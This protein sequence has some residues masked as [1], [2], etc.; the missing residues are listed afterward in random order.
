MGFNNPQPDLR[1]LLTTLK[2][3]GIFTP[4]EKDRHGYWKY[5]FDRKILLTLIYNSLLCEKIKNIIQMKDKFS[6]V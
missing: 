6:Y 4:I 5:K 3:M 2:T 1:V